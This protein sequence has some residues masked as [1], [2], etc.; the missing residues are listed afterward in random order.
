LIDF[1]LGML[2]GMLISLI[3]LSAFFSASET[4][5]MA[6]NRYRLR[7]LV[8]S[9]HRGARVAS[10]LLQRPDRLLGVILVGNNLVN[11]SAAATAT[12]IALELYGEWAIAWAP[13]PLTII[14]LI[15]AEVG[16]KTLAALHPERIAFPAAYILLPLLKI[17]Y[18]VVW[19]INL[20][21]N[22]TL[23]MMGISLRR[24]SEHLSTEELRSVVRETGNMIPASHRGHHGAALGDRGHRP[25]R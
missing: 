19:V 5:M 24:R 21:A 14:V 16:P 7:H 25:R 8:D 13:I 18:P 12:T 3:L 11:F 1:S 4:A 15:F 6:L 20:F 23:R 2:V 10:R 22:M 17:G 9:G